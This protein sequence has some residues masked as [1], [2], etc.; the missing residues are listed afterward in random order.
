M[1]DEE[2]KA[3][4]PL[5]ALGGVS[6]FPIR[7]KCASLPWHALKQGLGNRDAGTAGEVSTESANDADQSS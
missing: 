4:G 2:R 7:V 3:L 6:K 1:T 5:A